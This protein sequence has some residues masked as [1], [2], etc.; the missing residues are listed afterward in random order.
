MTDQQE[1]INWI[2]FYHNEIMKLEQK[3]ERKRKKLEQLEF[4]L[5]QSLIS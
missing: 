5:R 4:Q 2:E 3:I 1:I